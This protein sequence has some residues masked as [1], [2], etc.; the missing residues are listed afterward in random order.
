MKLRYRGIE[1]DYNP[2]AVAVSEG[3]VA[4]KYRGLDWRFH[5]LEKPPTLQPRLNLTYRGVK[6]SNQPVSAPTPKPETTSV[7]ERARWLAINQEKAARN[8]QAS[9]L[10]R[11][12]EEIGLA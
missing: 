1:Y 5:N 10:H 2:P 12:S 6:Y 3:E 11:S 8:R 7:A 4:G 9:M